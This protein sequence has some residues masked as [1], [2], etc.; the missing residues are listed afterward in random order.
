MA[1]E[2]T[3][4]LSAMHCAMIYRIAGVRPPAVLAQFRGLPQSDVGNRLAYAAKIDPAYSGVLAQRLG[5]GSGSCGPMYDVPLRWA[6]GMLARIPAML[7]DAMDVSEPEP[8]VDVDGQAEQERLARQ[9]AD[10]Y[11]EG[12]RRYEEE[13]LS[14]P[15]LD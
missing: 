5:Y 15:D 3:I 14:P 7:A 9:F 4:R 8:V 11:R 13:D 1:E 6:R 2:K 12:R 10:L